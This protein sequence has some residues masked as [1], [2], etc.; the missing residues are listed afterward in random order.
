[1]LSRLQKYLPFAKAGIKI[2]TT[3]KLDFL[4]YRFGDMLEAIITYFLWLSIFNSSSSNRISGFSFN[5]MK[6]YVFVSFFIS[7]IIKTGVNESIGEE[8][9][10]GSISIR[11]LKPINFVNTY[12]FTEI[13]I[14]LLQ[15]F[16]L[17][18]PIIIFITGSYIIFKIKLYYNFLYIIAF[19]ISFAISYLTN[20]Y[21]NVCVGFSSFTLKNTWGS[22]LFKQAIISFASG[23]VIPFNFLPNVISNIL[24]FMPFSSLIYFPTMIY[25]GKYTPYKLLNILI[26]QI[27]WLIF[28]YIL[29]KVIAKVALKK[30]EIQ[31]G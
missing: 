7:I 21:F 20:F 4:C 22:N 16:L 25:L 28:F 26:F 23:S 31:G 3:Y 30:L 11:L 2:S 9:K 12:L 18:I 5:E 29:S 15:I 10:D 27:F 24:Q 6:L 19:V 8:V 17:G 1:M 14:R 13:G